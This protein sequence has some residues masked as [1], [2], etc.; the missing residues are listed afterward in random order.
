MDSNAKS[1]K[2]EDI[3]V[4]KQDKI[5]LR[6]HENASLRERC[7]DILSVC[8]SPGRTRADAYADKWADVFEPK[9]AVAVYIANYVW[10]MTG[11]RH[12]VFWWHRDHEH[13]F[14]ARLCGE[15]FVPICTAKQGDI[16]ELENVK[17]KVHFMET[18]HPRAHVYG[19]IPACVLLPLE[20][21]KK[22]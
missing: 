2:E 22:Q 12:T 18:G 1:E 9:D 16:I 7:T 17:F 13:P 6:L 14:G 11:I 15:S 20:A 21:E 4:E 8:A 10:Y 3:S 19:Y 5:W